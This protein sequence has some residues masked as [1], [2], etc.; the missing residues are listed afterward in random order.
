[1]AHVGRFGPLHF[2]RDL[3]LNALNNQNAFKRYYKF[4]PSL[5]GGTVG[6]A[7]NNQFWGPAYDSNEM[8]D[9]MIWS[10]D[11]FTVAGRQLRFTMRSS[12]NAAISR[13]GIQWEVEDTTSGVLFR[14]QD[15]MNIVNGNTLWSVPTAGPL[16]ETPGVCFNT[17]PAGG[18]QINAIAWAEV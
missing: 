2:R 6:T 15:F 10:T 17:S 1:M 14:T 9:D 4:R 8:D 3:F 11:P 12:L 16:I 13:R 18:V 7:L 5:L